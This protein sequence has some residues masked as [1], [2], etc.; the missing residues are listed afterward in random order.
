M[1]VSGR[2]LAQS[3]LASPQRAPDALLRWHFRQAVL[4]NVKG[5]GSPVLES[6]SDVL[7]AVYEAPMAAERMDLEVFCR[8]V[9][10]KMAEEG[11]PGGETGVGS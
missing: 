5:A 1:H 4:A 8:L 10:S 6:D 11:G 7:A 2:L 3:F 9:A